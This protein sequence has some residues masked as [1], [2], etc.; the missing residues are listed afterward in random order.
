MSR[1]WIRY[2]VDKS[3]FIVNGVIAVFHDVIVDVGKEPLLPSFHQSAVFTV[4]F[5]LSLADDETDFLDSVVLVAG[6]D[7]FPVL[8]FFFGLVFRGV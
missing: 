5:R 7:Q 3:A 1:T 4:C 8:F 2:V 6:D